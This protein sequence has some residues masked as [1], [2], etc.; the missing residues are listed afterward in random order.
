MRGEKWS[1]ISI[2]S[3]RAGSSPLARGKAY[4]SPLTHRQVGIIPACAGK[5]CLAGRHKRELRDH[6]RLRGE[7]APELSDRMLADGSSPL[8]RGKDGKSR[9]AVCVAGIIPACAGKRIR[10]RGVSR[11][12]GDHP[13][14]RGEKMCAYMCRSMAGGSSPLARGKAACRWP[15]FPWVR[16]IPACAGKS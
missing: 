3:S 10:F 5:S 2:N 16:I 12:R 14:L 13:R 15:R 9:H 6:P 4:P 11:R 1:F 8:A 7:K